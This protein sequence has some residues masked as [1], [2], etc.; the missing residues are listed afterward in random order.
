MLGTCEKLICQQQAHQNLLHILPFV[1]EKDPGLAMA[2]TCPILHRCTSTR[3]PGSKRQWLGNPGAGVP[4]T[5]PTP[6]SWGY[7]WL[8]SGPGSRTR[9][10]T[11]EDPRP[12]PRSPEMRCRSACNSTRRENDLTSK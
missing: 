6:G 10:P 8:P 11:H 4:G 3:S 12:R 9:V 7:K 5:E 2:W 1:G